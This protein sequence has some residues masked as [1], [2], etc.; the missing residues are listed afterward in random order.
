MKLTHPYCRPAGPWLRGNLHTHSTNSDG[1]L[2][3]AELVELYASHGYDFLAIS[4]HDTFTPPLAHPTLVGVPAVEVSRGGSHLLSV[5][6]PQV[7][8]TSLTRAEI[9]GQIAADGGLAILAHPNWLA[10]YQHWEQAQLE[11][12]G[13]YHGIEIFNSVIDFLEGEAHALDRW[14]QLLSKGRRVW[15]YAHDDFHRPGNGPRGWNR[16]A[17]AERTPESIVAALQAGSCYASSG[18]FIERIE[19]DEESFRIVAPEASELRFVTRY[20]KVLQF[21][22]GGSGSYTF[23]GNEGYVRA[24]AYGRGKQAAWTQPVW[25]TA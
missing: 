15:G 18:V 16:V 6:T 25:V 7:Y 24:E 22:E 3:P 1:T 11:V 5:G 17:A 13:P 2:T 19:V 23:Q 4:D 10:H 9:L 14:D 12:L 8:D 20:G 21:V